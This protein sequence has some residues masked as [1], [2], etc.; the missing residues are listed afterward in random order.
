MQLA[1]ILILVALLATAVSNAFPS[2]C[3]SSLTKDPLKVLAKSNIA[4]RDNFD[5]YG[6]NSILSRFSKRENWRDSDDN[7]KYSSDE[8][9]FAL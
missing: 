2:L 1:R 7:S 3:V 8:T 5:P 9:N 6:L 4:R